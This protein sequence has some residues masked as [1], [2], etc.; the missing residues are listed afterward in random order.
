MD[1]SK[2]IVVTH[3]LHLPDDHGGVLGSSG[4]F[5]AVVGEFAEP[6]LVAVFCEDLL[7]VTGKLFPADTQ[8][9]LSN[10]YIYDFENDILIMT[11]Y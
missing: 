7:C 3:R 1:L 10:Y 9:E 4:Q 2:R 11:K 6:D 5:S 8:T